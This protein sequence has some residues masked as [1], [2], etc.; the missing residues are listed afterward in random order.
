MQAMLAYEPGTV[1]HALYAYKFAHRLGDEALMQRA[2][3][4]P[5]RFPDLLAARLPKQL[6]LETVGLLAQQVGCDAI[7]LWVLL[8][9]ATTGEQ[10]AASRS[11]SPPVPCFICGAQLSAGEGVYREVYRLGVPEDRKERAHE[12]CLDRAAVEARREGVAL[13]AF[14][15]EQF[16]ETRR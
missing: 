13:A 12:R 8:N 9:V 10:P 6:S 11:L 4:S 1:G 15:A 3:C 16:E 7:G 5:Q 14:I 2:R